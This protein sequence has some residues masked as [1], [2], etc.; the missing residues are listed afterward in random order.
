M[1]LQET[2]GHARIP[3]FITYVDPSG[4]STAILVKGS[5][6]AVQH[7]TPRKECEHTLVGIP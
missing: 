3:G 6:A 1:A 7:L 2:N 5:I 4:K